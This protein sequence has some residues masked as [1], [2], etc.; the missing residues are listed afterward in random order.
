[1][2]FL[3]KE[4]EYWDWKCDSNGRTPALGTQ[5]PEFKPSPQQQS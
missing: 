2:S 4:V 3:A 1:M 5:S